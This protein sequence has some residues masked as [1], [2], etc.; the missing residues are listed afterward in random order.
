MRDRCWDE[1]A[2]AADFTFYE[3]VNRSL[4]DVRAGGFGWSEDKPMHLSI[5]AMLNDTAVSVDT[6]MLGGRDSHSAQPARIADLI[7]HFLMEISG[8]VP[9]PLTVVVQPQ[10]REVE[11][12]GV[13][14]RFAGAHVEGSLRWVGAAD[15]GDV[16]VIITTN[17]PDALTA[18]STCSHTTLPGG[19]PR[20]N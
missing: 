3:P 1:A 18:I 12:D 6:Q 10:D 16:R 5:E 14:A 17:G 9:L 13:P 4:R 20:G 8:A 7:W 15:I 19:G 11:V 2:S